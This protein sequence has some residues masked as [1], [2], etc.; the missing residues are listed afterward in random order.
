MGLPVVKYIFIIGQCHV[1]TIMQQTE[2]TEIFFS[3]LFEVLFNFKDFKVTIVDF[4]GQHFVSA[5]YSKS[6]DIKI[7]CCT[8][9]LKKIYTILLT[10]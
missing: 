6:I 3:L 10:F 5:A 9:N 1:K 7:L 2:K 4:C 8:T